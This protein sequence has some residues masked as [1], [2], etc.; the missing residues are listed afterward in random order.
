MNISEIWQFYPWVQRTF[1]NWCRLHEFRAW[2]VVTVGKLSRFCAICCK[3]WE[4]HFPWSE[5]E[6]G[7]Q[8]LHNLP[9]ARIAVNFGNFAC[10]YREPWEIDANCVNFVWFV[11]TVGKLSRFCAICCKFWEFHSPW[12]E[13][14]NGRRNLRNLPKARIAANFGNFAHGYREPW[15][16]DAN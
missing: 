12:S 9:K 11:V 2:F 8:N 13:S 6:N 5:L 10:G 14:E 1:G 4:F 7:W 3:F 15:E 16:I